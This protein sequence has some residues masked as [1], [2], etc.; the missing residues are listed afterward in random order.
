MPRLTPVAPETATGKA[1]ELLN[2]VQERTGRIPNMVRLMANSPPTLQ[3]YLSFA[4]A[5]VDAKLDKDIRDLIA[6]A[7]AQ[8]S[9]SDYTLSAVHAL[10]RSGG[11][12]AEDL[13]V[14]R[15]AQA[16]DAKTAAALR[17]AAKI[18]DARGHLSAADVDAMR[19]V[20]FS[21]GEIAEIIAS[22]V[23]NIFRS[24]FNLV[25]A[26]DIDFPV[27]RTSVLAA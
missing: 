6:L 26:P 11:L 17:F 10:G 25:A 13:T 2:A 15:R 27:V 21:D 24:Y 12:G 20:G 1:K 19:G 16:K 4:T 18:V 22:V 5:M 14:A 3:A 7:V 23:L 8:A 9:G